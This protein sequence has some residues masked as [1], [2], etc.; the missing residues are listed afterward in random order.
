MGL[1]E[2]VVVEL[3]KTTRKNLAANLSGLSRQ[4]LF[5]EL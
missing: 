4:K 1:N 2:W 5:L 3:L